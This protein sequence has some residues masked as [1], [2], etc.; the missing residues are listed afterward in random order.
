MKVTSREKLN[1]KLMELYENEV[2]ILKALNHPNICS[3]IDDFE[4]SR[5]NYLVLEYCN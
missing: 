1:S 3:Y 5:F 4:D 2:N